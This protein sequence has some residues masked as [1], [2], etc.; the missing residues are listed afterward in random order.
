MEVLLRFARAI[1]AVN[2]FV[3]RM[4]SWLTLFM[5]LLG[6]YNAVTRKLSQTIGIDLSKNTYIEMQWYMFAL[7]FLWGAAYTLKANAHVRVDVL[8][9]RLPPRGKAWVDILGTIFFLLPFVALVLYTAVPIVYDSWRIRE[10]SPDPGG[11]PRYPIK[12]ALIVGFVLLFFQGISELIKRIAFLKGVDVEI[13][14]E[15]EELAL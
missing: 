4:V 9:S 11:L 1:D 6:V 3:G 15:E 7:V 12:A 8:Y 10:V 14:T 2:E 13:A 5:V